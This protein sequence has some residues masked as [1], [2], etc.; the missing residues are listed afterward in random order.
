[1]LT[2]WFTL[3]TGATEQFATNVVHTFT[4]PK[5]F[6]PRANGGLL[7]RDA[8]LAVIVMTDGPQVWPEPVAMERAERDPHRPALGRAVHGGA[9][10]RRDGAC[11]R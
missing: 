9:A 3:D 8:T 11:A 10:G 1:V 2:E 7:R 5:I 6:D 4:A